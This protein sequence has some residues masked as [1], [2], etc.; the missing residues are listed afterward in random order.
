MRIYSQNRSRF[1]FNPLLFLKV[2][3]ILTTCVSF[4]IISNRPVDTNA[5]LQAWSQRNSRHDDKNVAVMESKS[6]IRALS[7]AVNT[8]RCLTI[9]GCY[10]SIRC[11]DGKEPMKVPVRR[12]YEQQA[13]CTGDLTA[14][15]TEPN[16]KC[17][18]YSFGIHD[19]TE[20]EEKIN[21]EFGCDVFAFDPTSNF[22]T[23]VAPGVTFHQLGLQGADVDVSRTHS[24]SYDAL[25]PSK[26]RTLGEIIESMGHTGRTIDILRLDCEGCE[27]GVLKQLACSGESQLVKQLM[28]EMHFQKNLGLAT[29]DD[30]LIAADAITC[31]ESERWGIASMEK[32]G[33]GPKDAQYIDSVLKFVRDPFFLQYVTMKR[34]TKEQNA[35]WELFGDYVQADSAALEYFSENYQKHGYDPSKWPPVPKSE[36]DARRMK[37]DAAIQKYKPLYGDFFKPEFKTF[38]VYPL[39]DD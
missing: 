36:Y 24:V 20:W 29:D 30:I 7:D 25:D 26:L 17:L 9:P 27:W 22:P 37:S 16:Q 13:F 19:N 15:S 6:R 28:V 31:L 3:W 38:D 5:S 18:V 39:K 2:F 14:Q 4:Y 8:L 1:S 32:S 21:R 34:M 12:T 10:P 35:S 23:N 11:A 33:C